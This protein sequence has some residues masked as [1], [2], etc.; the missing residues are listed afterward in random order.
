MLRGW[1]PALA[2]RCS[3]LALSIV[4]AFAPHPGLPPARGKEQAGASA[5]ADDV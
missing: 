4:D 5:E 2:L 1:R 3:V